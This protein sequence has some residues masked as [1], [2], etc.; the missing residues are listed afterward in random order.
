MVTVL[1]VE[2]EH[3]TTVGQVNSVGLRAVTTSKL[4]E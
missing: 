4:I 3:A 2:R 1:V